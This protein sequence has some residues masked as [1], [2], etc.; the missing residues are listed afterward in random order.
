MPRRPSS[1]RRSVDRLMDDEPKTPKG[2]PA[3]NTPEHNAWL[4]R[5]FGWGQERPHSP[6]PK[7][8]VRHGEYAYATFSDRRPSATLAAQPPA[9]EERERREA[10]AARAAKPGRYLFDPSKVLVLGYKP[11]WRL[12]A[13]IMKYDG[14][15][16]FDTRAWC[17]YCGIPDGQMEVEHVARGRRPRGP[18]GRVI[19]RVVW[20]PQRPVQTAREYERNHNLPVGSVPDFV[21]RELALAHALPANHPHARLRRYLERRGETTAPTV[22]N[23]EAVE[24][25]RRE[26]Q[27]R[28]L[29]REGEA[30]SPRSPTLGG[31]ESPVS[32]SSPA[33]Q[34]PASVRR[35][36]RTASRRASSA[37]DRRVSFAARI[38]TSSAASKS[39]SSTSS[40]RTSSG[41]SRRTSASTPTRRSPRSPGLSDRFFAV[42]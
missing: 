35:S 22:E 27:S 14:P 5:G 11:S 2:T 25:E 8:I 26:L 30:E 4:A 36:S 16:S 31:I 12:T 29:Q 18:D 17:A 37:A 41:S 38:R 10:E 13:R 28:A 24:R 40:R 23:L 1:I 42:L 9:I 15:G 32:P 20:D 6:R 3:Y 34:A 19:D 7:T 33:Q 39:T 21:T